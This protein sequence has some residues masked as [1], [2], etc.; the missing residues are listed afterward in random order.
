MT[1]TTTTTGSYNEWVGANVYDSNNDKLGSID[2]I[3]VD[4]QTGQPEWVTVTTGWFG[5]STQFVPIAGSSPHEDGLKVPYTTDHIKDAPSIDG[6]E[7]LEAQEE[8]RLYEHYGLSHDATDH[9]SSYGGRERADE[10]YEYDDVRPAAGRDRTDATTGTGAEVTLNEEQLR[11]D[12]TRHDAGTV[13]LRKYVTTEDVDVTV[14]VRKQVARIVRT[15]A[16]AS[17]PG[18]ITDDE[19]VEEVTLAQEEITLDK[20][21]VAKETVGIE[22]ETVTEQRDVSGTVRREEV[23]I[24]GDVETGR[25]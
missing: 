23:D 13:R 20:N 21:V 4:D 14:P 12:K 6:D 22:T 3:F 2:A 7:H 17:T 24:D 18:S 15:P 16:S 8:H 19:V 9:E 11:V 10:G 5:T 1:N 25:S